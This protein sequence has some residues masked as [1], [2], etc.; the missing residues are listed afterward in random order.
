MKKLFTA[1][2]LLTAVSLEAQTV[3]R[4]LIEGIAYSPAAD[5]GVPF[6]IEVKLVPFDKETHKEKSYHGT[7]ETPP[8][9]VCSELSIT[10]NGKKIAI[11]R[12]AIADL[13]NITDIN[14]PNG[15]ENKTWVMLVSGGENAGA[16]EVELVFNDEKLI[17]RRFVDI[18]NEGEERVYY[19]K[20]DF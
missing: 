8:Y 15:E 20:K 19:D 12:E 9:F 13:A 6:A 11:P 10:I 3:T 16:Y 2:F 7:D 1:I 17:Q 4:Q 14:S 5:A 18:F